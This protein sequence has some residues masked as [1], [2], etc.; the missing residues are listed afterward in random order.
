M[1]QRDRYAVYCTVE[2]KVFMHAALG[3]TIDSK[4]AILF[5]NPST[6]FA[7]TVLLVSELGAFRYIS[8][9]ATKLLYCELGRHTFNWLT[10]DPDCATGHSS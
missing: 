8:H 6:C 10:L 7:S 3:C 4:G 1:L 2:T 9:R 5:P